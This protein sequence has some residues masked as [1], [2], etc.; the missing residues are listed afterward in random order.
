MRAL[1][2]TTLQEHTPEEIPVLALD[3][4]LAEHNNGLTHEDADRLAAFWTSET[5][6]GRVSRTLLRWLSS[7]TARMR[8]KASASESQCQ[9]QIGKLTDLICREWPAATIER[10]GGRATRLYTAVSPI[11]L[12]A[13]CPKDPGVARDRLV[14]LL[15]TEAPL[16]LE[17]V[18]DT[19]AR[20]QKSE[21]AI[22]MDIAFCCHV[23][24][25][26][27]MRIARLVND[28]MMAIPALQVRS[29]V[30][31]ESSSYDRSLHPLID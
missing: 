8:Q 18:G 22:L 1:Q 7:R 5:E 12:L 31:H 3:A 21:D 10:Y 17:S 25:D 20:Y 16:L 24:S 11:E 2:T 15:K 28:L 4:K 6:Q 27:R 13:S 26:T 9:Q 19:V 14:D 30:C 29:C 23:V